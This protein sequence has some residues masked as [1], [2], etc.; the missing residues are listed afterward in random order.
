M[1]NNVG[2]V[3]KRKRAVIVVPNKKFNIGFD[4]K[5]ACYSILVMH[6]P[7]RCESEW[8]KT[9]ATFVDAVRD[10][11]FIGESPLVTMLDYI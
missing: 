5:D 4:D 3:R 7:W 1:L 8:L 9:Y 11:V 6:H 10:I 2:S